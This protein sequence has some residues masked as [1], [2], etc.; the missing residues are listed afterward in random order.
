MMM[1]G[2][3]SEGAGYI[4][5]M[6]MHENPFVLPYFLQYLIC[7]T[8][9]PAFFAAAIY[10]C[11][12]HVVVVYGEGISRIR[13]RT[14]TFLFMGFDFFSLVLQAVGGGIA[15][16]V[17]FTNKKMVCDPL[18][19]MNC[20]TDAR[21]RSILAPIFLLLVFRFKLPVCSCSL[22]AVLSSSGESSLILLCATKSIW[23]L[24]K[25]QSSNG[26]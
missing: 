6:L 1:L 15:A 5:R 23:K 26:S 12:G 4:A 14:Y 21:Y 25:A 10:L 22:S 9:G 7:L 17:P 16:S 18:I 13:P 11:L 19:T 24:Q 2:L 3:A 8:L 20:I